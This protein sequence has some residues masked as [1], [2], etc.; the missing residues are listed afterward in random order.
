ELPGSPPLGGP[1]LS[2]DQLEAAF[3]RRGGYETRVIP[4]ESESYEINPPTLLDF[5]YRE[6]RWCQGNMQYLRLLATP[7]L[8]PVSRIQ[9]LI[10][11]GMYVAQA[12]WIGMIAV[13]CV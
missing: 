6:L 11:I 13:G 12:T 4:V 5:I 8:K 7:G 9:L 2:H 1:V 3:M 10:A